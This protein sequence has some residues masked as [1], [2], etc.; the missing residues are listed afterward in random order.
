VDPSIFAAGCCFFVLIDSFI[1]A[2]EVRGFDDVLVP[3]VRQ[4][5]CI[6]PVPTKFPQPFAH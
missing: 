2:I 5:R 1:F 3:Q 6:S 4:A